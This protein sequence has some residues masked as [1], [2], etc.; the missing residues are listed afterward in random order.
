MCIQ[1]IKRVSLLLFFA[2]S[3]AIQAKANIVILNGLTHENI[4]SP[5]EKYRGTIQVQNAGTEARSIKVYVRD[6]WYSHLGESRNDEPG[7][8]ERSNANWIDF[9]PKLLTLQ[10]DEKAVIDF[11]VSTPMV[12]SLCGTYWSVIMVEGLAPQDTAK[13]TGLKIHTAIRYAVQ[14]I[15]NIEETG[16]RDLQFIGLELDDSKEENVL[17]VAL[18]NT[19]ERILKPELSI[20]LFNDAGE[21]V[22]VFKAERRKTFPGTSILQSLTLVGV[23][24]GSYS[25]VLVAN[26]DAD[27]IFGTNFTLEI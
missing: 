10:P 27:H 1:N 14:I 23:K 11:E 24:P 25:A 7:T 13:S 2:L 3:I 26:C 16:K 15:T 17:N 5:G 4:S 9:S 8:L 19:G 6:Y 21:S 18:Q 12:D 22:G 20:E